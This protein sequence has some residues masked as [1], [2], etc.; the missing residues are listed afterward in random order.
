MLR[1]NLDA[2]S[3]SSSTALHLSSSYTSDKVT[4]PENIAP[5]DIDAD[6][7]DS[8][9]DKNNL[10]IAQLN[11][12]NRQMVLENL[13]ADDS[14]D[15]LILQEP[16]VNPI[17]LNIPKHPAWHEF[18]AY[19]YLASNYEEKTRTGIYVSKRTPSWNI[20]MLPSKSPYITAVEIKDT[21]SQIS[22]LRIL[23]VYNP[24][25][26]NTGL[27]ILKN[28][29]TEYNDRRV[30]TII[31]MDANLHHPNWNPVN[32]HHTHPQAKEL[33]KMSGQA[34]FMIKSQKNVPTFYPRAR[35]RP[36]TI[37]L[38]WINHKLSRRP[39]VCTT[40]SNNYGSDHQMLKTEIRLNEEKPIREHNS[41]RLDKLDEASYC[42][43]V[44]NQLSKI[45][46]LLDSIPGIDMMVESITDVILQAFLRQG[47]TVRTNDHRH[48]A[49][50]D[51]KKLRPLI[52][53]R[54]RARKWMILS[55]SPEATQCYWEWNHHVKYTITV[56][57][58]T[59]WREFLAKTQGGLTFKAFKYT[60]V[61]GSNS[62]AP[63]YRVDRTLA[64]D[65]HEQAKLL[66]TG[67]SIVNNECDVSDITEVEATNRPLEYQKIVE[68]EVM[69]V[70]RKLPAKKAKGGDGVPNELIKL[71]KSE[72][73]PVLTRLYDTC[74]KIGYFPT[75]WRT[76]TTAIL[77][78]HDKDDYS[79]AGAYRPIAL[80]SCLGKVFETVIA[81][82]LTY[83]A[84][85]NKV[86][87]QGH[88]GGRRQ[89]STDDAFV[90]LTSWVHHKWREG[91]I[92]SG[93]FLDVKSAYPSVHK[94]RL[95]NTLRKQACP[96]YM[97]RQ[98][99][100]YL[101]DRTTDLRL[102]DFLSE[103]FE[104]KDGLPQGSPLSVILYIIYN[105]SLLI[106]LDVNMKSDKISLGFI[107]D[108]THLVANTDI[109]L[110]I[111][112]LEEE[113]DKALL[114]GRRHGAIFDQKKAQIMHLTHKKHSN[115][116]VEFGNQLL[117]PKTEIRW[118]GLWLDPKLS[119]GT[120]IQKM[121]QRGKTTIAQLG[122]INRCFW[123]ISPKEAKTLIQT[124]LKPRLLF[125]CVVWFNTRTEGKVTSIF[126]LLQNAANRLILG[127]FKSSPT[128]HM[129]QNTNMIPFKI[130]AIRYNHNFMYKRLTAPKTH[131]TRQIVENELFFVP[132][133]LLSPVH[134]IL[135]KNDMYLPKTERLETIHPYPESPWCEPK[136]EVMNKGEDRKRVKEKI[137][138]KVA[139]EQLA[140]ACIVFTDGSY[141]PEVGGG[142]AAVV[143]DDVIKQS[144]KSLKG[145]SNYEM[146]AMALML[147]LLRFSAKL[148]ENPN[149][150]KAIAIFSD[151]QA[152]LDLYTNP[153]QPK[154]L[155]Y[156]AKLLQR[157]Q[158][159]I[160]EGKTVS[161]YWTPGHEGIELNERADEAAKEA[162]EEG[163]DVGTLPV[164]LGS[165]LRHTKDNIKREVIPIKTFKKK[166]K[167]VAEAL[168]KLEKG[169]AASIFQLRCG[170]CPLRKFL[171]QIGVEDDD[172]CDYCRVVES[173]NHF[174]IFCRKFSKQRQVFR[175]KLKEEHINIDINST[176]RL[177]DTPAVYPY[178]AQYIEDTGRFVH[179]K[180]YLDK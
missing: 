93:L 29:L 53:E 143:D 49:W 130:S 179:L 92:V 137:L 119:F 140:G 147:G 172:K 57:K 56:L 74:L 47:K 82:R 96:E 25:R 132:R 84:E 86:L 115:P 133:N 41:A 69:E 153:I 52:Q 75:A 177:L 2:T 155:Q 68:Y 122:R 36:T 156:I 157:A 112:D 167:Y 80:L 63:L 148:T 174:L 125:G 87:A 114:W 42:A 34:G 105:S 97:V 16:W 161:L 48:K 101:D 22:S 35:G 18:M 85:T 55:G 45:P 138:E 13:L 126:N 145:I 60:Q 173:P 151:S 19:D 70:I 5:I 107:D 164:G 98:V 6:A 51:E 152:A 64:T 144:Y 33:F 118:L 158:R 134:R 7:S 116:A 178:L 160:P 129:A 37:D 168:N 14:F 79:E 23:S 66:F 135:R 81:R 59:H 124:V 102:Q 61:Q 109:D 150:Y 1:R 104:V 154:T 46:E 27:P 11:C 90:I 100:E 10:R 58:R 103:K 141:I 89:H 166:A 28:W 9:T 94:K 3:H 30:P 88:M 149:K 4:E 12:F 127:A 162:T 39:V 76:A 146:E 17:T 176:T 73:V 40:S 128:N 15:I 163:G 21:G 43:T 165:L 72:L 159:L 62:V 65:K 67:T 106:N 170:H 99:E 44:E 169:Q 26:H 175:Q 20:V 38:T 108:I 31:G 139:E 136:W 91:K 142:A 50:W 117:K 121:Y 171:H 32:Y 123:G 24:P 131:P 111:M 113:S 110:N 120:H 180:T 77:Q 78:K 8:A 54:N 95:A 83:W 71:A